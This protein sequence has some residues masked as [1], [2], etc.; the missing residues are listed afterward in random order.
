MGFWICHDVHGWDHSVEVTYKGLE[1][2]HREFEDF[3]RVPGSLFNAQ[4]TSIGGSNG[5]DAF[6]IYY[7]SQFN[8]GE[9]N[10]RWTKRN[11]NDQLTYSPDGVWRQEA[12]DGSIFSF[13][14]GI[15]DTE[16]DEKFDS[17]AV[18]NGVPFTT[19]G[20]HDHIRTQNNF[21][22]LNV[23]GEL[24]YHH[25]RW[26]VGIR[27]KGAA[28]INFLELDRNLVFNDAVAGSGTRN[29]HTV[30]DSPGFVSELSLLAGWQLT[31]RLSVRASYDFIWLT[32]VALAPA[33]LDYGAPRAR[34]V[35]NSS[36]MMLNGFSLGL[37]MHW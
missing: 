34:Q 6:L 35:V 8:S 12:E 10:L 25:D 22:G 11:G 20:S 32:S 2:W 17:I 13:L 7:K 9:L 28:C 29:E 27:G 4:N 16:L 37:Q 14:L 1:D 23:G 30:L 33:Q 26:Y 18:R 19:F 5:A 24:D 15:R 31:P 3:A 36:D 21:L